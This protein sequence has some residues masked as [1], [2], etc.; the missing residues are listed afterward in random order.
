MQRIYI[1]LILVHR[2]YTLDSA[3]IIPTHSP[4]IKVKFETSFQLKLQIILKL[5]TLLKNRTASLLNDEPHG[6]FSHHR[7]LK[8]LKPQLVF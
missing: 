5:W 4:N 6:E 8:L 2:I 3:I 1:E 7:I